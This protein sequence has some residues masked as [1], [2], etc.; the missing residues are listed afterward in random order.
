MLAANV[1]QAR[2][3][4]TRARPWRDRRA[5]RSPALVARLLE[6]MKGYLGLAHTI[7]ARDLVV[8]LG[9]QHD[10]DPARTIRELVNAL[11]EL[12]VPVGSVNF[13][14]GG[15]GYFVVSNQAELDKCV[16]NYQSRARENLLKYERLTQAFRHGPS[17]PSLLAQE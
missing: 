3:A 7:R 9:L 4:G 10:S 5:Q 11:I 1:P 17:Q 8:V 12:G 15:G 14:S 6:V 13:E 16:R 2:P